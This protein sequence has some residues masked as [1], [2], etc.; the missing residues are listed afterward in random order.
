MERITTQLLCNVYREFSCKLEDEEYNISIHQ[1]MTGIIEEHTFGL[2]REAIQEVINDEL[3][4]EESNREWILLESGEWEDVHWHSYYLVMGVREWDENGDIT[5]Y[6]L[7]K[8]HMILA[9]ELN[10]KAK[11]DARML[12]AKIEQG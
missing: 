3:C 10:Q 12:S 1:I 6:W 7:N 9:E 5:F 11:A 2:V 4:P 8:E